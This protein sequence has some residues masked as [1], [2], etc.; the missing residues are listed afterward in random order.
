ELVAQCARRDRRG[1]VRGA[2]RR[3]GRRRPPHPGFLGRR[4]RGGLRPGPV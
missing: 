2:A 4:P 3:G 1:A